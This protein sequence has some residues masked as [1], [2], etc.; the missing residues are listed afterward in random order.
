MSVFR[1]PPI[2]IAELYAAQTVVQAGFAKVPLQSIREWKDWVKLS[3]G[4]IVLSPGVQCILF[5][6][7]WL[8]GKVAGVSRLYS[9]D[10]G[11]YIWE[12]SNEQPASTIMVNTPVHFNPALV[13]GRIQIQIETANGGT[14]MGGSSSFEVSSIYLLRIR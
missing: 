13:T 12:A 5:G 8:V 11:K 14:V 3:S 10:L 1:T 6:T 2:D 7:I 9:V 4:D